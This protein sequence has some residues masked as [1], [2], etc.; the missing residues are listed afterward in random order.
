MLSVY[1]NSGKLVAQNDAW[2]SQVISGEYQDSVGPENIISTDMS[3]GGFVL[4]PGDTALIAD[5]PPGAYTYQITS[6]SNAQGE[7]LGEV[8]E[9]P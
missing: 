3:V 6:A 7:A 9:L 5:L 2:M 8:Y 1:D 4:S